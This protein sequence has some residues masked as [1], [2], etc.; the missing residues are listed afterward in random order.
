MAAVQSG[1]GRLE[2]L[3]EMRAELQKKESAWQEERTQFQQ[4]AAGLSADIESLAESNAALLAALEGSE[5]LETLGSKLDAKGLERR[6]AELERELQ[7][8][9][10]RAAAAEARL[11]TAGAITRWG[12]GRRRVWCIR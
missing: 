8:K 2:Q 1:R 9:T 4:A 7:A 3:E 12:R 6:T 11:A 10:E 5:K